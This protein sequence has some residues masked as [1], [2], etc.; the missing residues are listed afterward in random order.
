MNQIRNFSIISHID[1]GKTTLADRFLEKTGT[2]PER[3]MCSQFLDKMELERE[4]GITIKLQPIRMLWHPY[5]RNDAEETQN[6]AENDFLFRDLT[7]KIRGILFQVRKKIGLGHKEQVYHNALEIELKKAGIGFESKKNIQILYEK[8]SIGVYQPDFIVDEKVLIELKALP[9]IGKS[10]IEQIW[11]YLKGCQYKLALLVN[12]G[13]KDLEIKRIVYDKVRLRNS[14]F[15][16]RSSAQVESYTLNLIDTPGHVDFTYEV[17]RSLAACEGAILLVDASKGIQAQ[18]LANLRLAQKNRLKIIPVV[19]K[20]DLPNARTGEVKKELSALLE[21]ATDDIL[22][23]SAKTGEGVDLLLEKIITEVPPPSGD[24]KAPL[25]ALV[26][27]SHFD[28]YKGDIAYIRVVDG[29]IKLN[30]LL[31]FYQTPVRFVAEE[32]GYFSKGLEKKELLVAGEIGYIA[33]GLKNP[34][35]VRIGD[36]LFEANQTIDSPLPGYEEV[37]PKLWASVFCS[38][39]DEFPKLKKAID[40]LSLNDP[41]LSFQPDNS[42]VFGPGFMGGFLGVLHLE[43]T[44]DRLEREFDLDLVV[45]APST[46]Y[47]IKTQNKTFEIKKP[48]ELPADFIE[49]SE[50]YV[51]VEIVTPNTFLGGIIE[52]VANRR[53]VIKDTKYLDQKTVILESELPLAEIIFDF[54]DQLKSL[55]SGFAS[56]NYKLL[57]YVKG[58]LTKLEVWVA[59]QPVDAFS[60]IIPRNKA[61][62]LAKSAVIK[63]QNLIPRQL[64]EVIIQA[65]VGGKILASEKIFALRKD[66]IAKLYGGDRTRKDKLLKK[67]KA[68]KKKMKSIGSVDIPKDAFLKYLKI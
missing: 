65:K 61:H 47:Q 37:F 34:K 15:G 60:R 14:A 53:G 68:G 24:I 51:S 28:E 29:E 57:G 56:M 2:I 25:K 3:E 58:D 4:R 9:E 1:H 48:S 10:Q 33:T 63:L 66:V 26:F 5:R 19:N 54:Y 49:I 30:D 59:G 46:S 32:V 44:R 64:F 22:S 45:S 42:S 43:I 18:T 55:S 11:S 52:L 38:D 41:S 35:D 50:P 31:K 67:Q 8:K 16:Q 36:T 7:Y 23:I 6:I 40:E 17:S 13:S 21:I 27:D 62:A 39:S 12:F 20:I